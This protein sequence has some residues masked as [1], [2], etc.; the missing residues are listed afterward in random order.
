MGN[1]AHAQLNGAEEELYK[2]FVNGFLYSDDPGGPA[3]EVVNCR[4]QLNMGAKALPAAQKRDILQSSAKEAG[5]SG[6]H[7]QEGIVGSAVIITDG[8]IEHS[9]H[10]KKRL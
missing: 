7:D 2:P 6:V 10:Y 8:R 3:K 5:K 9:N 1:R 4:S